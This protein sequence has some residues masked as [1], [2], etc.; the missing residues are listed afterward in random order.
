MSTD[1]MRKFVERARGDL[2]AIIAQ[3]APREMI[4]AAIV[5]AL[6]T[7]ATYEQM[8]AD[9][10]WTV[11]ELQATRNAYPDLQSATTYTPVE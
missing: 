6:E 3:E 10:A 8:A 4:A 11:E 7:G 1:P 9:T 2:V 5:E